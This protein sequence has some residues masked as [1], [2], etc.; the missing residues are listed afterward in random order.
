MSVPSIEEDL[1]DFHECLQSEE[2]YSRIY[3]GLLDFYFEGDRSERVSGLLELIEEVLS[4]E[5]SELQKK[6]LALMLLRD[7]SN[8]ES[9]KLSNC[10]ARNKTLLIHLYTIATSQNEK[11]TGL[12]KGRSKRHESE[13]EKLEAQ[14]KQL[15]IE[16]ICCLKL[17]FG[18]GDSKSAEVLRRLYRKLRKHTSALPK[19]LACLEPDENQEKVENQPPKYARA[20]TYD[21]PRTESEIPDY[22]IRGGS[23]QRL[24][25]EEK[26]IDFDSQ[27]KSAAVLNNLQK[28]LKI[29]RDNKCLKAE[30]LL[31][32][33]GNYDKF[34]SKAKE[35]ISELKFDI[36]KTY[37]EI[38]AFKQVLNCTSEE[39]KL[40]DEI[41]TEYS[42]VAEIEA[43]LQQ[44]SHKATMFV[45]LQKVSAFFREKFIVSEKPVTKSLKILLPKESEILSQTE[46]C[47]ET[48]IRQK[49]AGNGPSSLKDSARLSKNISPSLKSP[50]S[51]DS[52]HFFNKDFS[53]TIN[54]QITDTQKSPNAKDRTPVRSLNNIDEKEQAIF[55]FIKGDKELVK[56]L[57]NIKNAIASSLQQRNKPIPSKVLDNNDSIIERYSTTSRSV[58]LSEHSQ[59]TPKCKV[60]GDQNLFFPS[61]KSFQRR[62]LDK[63]LSLPDTRS[64]NLAKPERISTKTMDNKLSYGW[65]T[66]DGVSVV[67]CGGGSKRTQE[68]T[69]SDGYNMKPRASRD[70]ANLSDLIIPAKFK[71]DRTKART[72][73][74][75]STIESGSL[76]HDNKRQTG[77][78]ETNDAYTIKDKAENLRLSIGGENTLTSILKDLSPKDPYDNDSPDLIRDLEN[79]LN[80]FH[81]HQSPSGQDRVPAMSF[82]EKRRRTIS[83]IP[84]L[85]DI[86][87]E[88]NSQIVKKSSSFNE[89][90]KRLQ[91]P[92]SPLPIEAFR[93]IACKRRGVVFENAYLSIC[94][95][96]GLVEDKKQAQR[97]LKIT[98]TIENK[99]DCELSNFK[100]TFTTDPNLNFV[101]LPE[102]TE[103]S[104]LPKSLTKIEFVVSI[105]KHSC[106]HLPIK[107]SIRIL[108]AGQSKELCCKFILPVTY[109]MFM[110]FF[111]QI[112]NQEFLAAWRTPM[113]TILKSDVLTVTNTLIKTPGDFKKILGHLLINPESFDGDEEPQ[114]YSLLGVFCLEKTKMNFL[115]KIHWN[116]ANRNAT[117]EVACSERSLREGE[118]ILQT[119]QF[120]FCH[121][122]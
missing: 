90:E 87:I 60:E 20:T 114:T 79:E 97:C 88:R 89:L 98:V 96:Y 24:E 103:P 78:H 44:E 37:M 99:T 62:R 86:K 30:E 43:Y 33:T 4:D 104:I 74:Q 49:S 17:K 92:S 41:E 13:T 83:S 85:P 48:L 100:I 71:A 102:K 45:L 117:F 27:I 94:S 2:N 16:C 18:E 121:S 70:P 29:Y 50:G 75:L 12:Q 36:T 25:G 118:F 82:T 109:N 81:S 120:L 58:T 22:F 11:S 26:K 122:G 77:S 8:I 7:S 66:Q 95:N 111:S 54:Y 47:S 76:E 110:S 21:R 80:A 55:K 59:G 67:E 108:E 65:Q 101:K 5:R 53:A 106:T 61:E 113:G 93:E 1:I 3:E 14:Y 19:S 38:T 73:V 35:A 15:A 52:K 84:E 68:K 28:L 64:Q 116:P 46:G 119:L 34:V 10:I 57:Q 69:K 42:H 91:L 63:L 115:L 40:H 6:V 23:L 105:A 31:G 39:R 72:V 107:C 56:D 112:T 32:I 9:K 51:V